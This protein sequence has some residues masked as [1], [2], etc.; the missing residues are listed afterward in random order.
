M[1]PEEGKNMKVT[2]FYDLPEVQRNII[3]HIDKAYSKLKAYES[4]KPVKGAKNTNMHL[5][6]GP[7]L[8]D[9][10]EVTEY[11]VAEGENRWSTA[12]QHSRVIQYKNYFYGKLGMWGKWYC[13]IVE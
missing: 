1:K 8:V 5:F 2:G 12:T 13:L 3:D 7:K 9:N 6:S 4:F 11:W 10:S